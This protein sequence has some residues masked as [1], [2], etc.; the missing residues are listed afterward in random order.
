M[1]QWV[2]Q[3][4][5]VVTA[6]SSSPVALAGVQL[7]RPGRGGACLLALLVAALCVSHFSLVGHSPGDGWGASMQA[8]L[9]DAFKAFVHPCSQVQGHVVGRHP[10][11]SE[12]GDPRLPHGAETSVD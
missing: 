8:Q 12:A 7:V 9:A 5:C 3:P 6:L 11:R 10:A 4:C 1:L 2:P